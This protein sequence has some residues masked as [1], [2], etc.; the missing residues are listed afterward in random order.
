MTTTIYQSLKDRVVIIT[1]GGQGPMR[2]SLQRRALFRLSP[3]S[4]AK[5]GRAL[6]PRLNRRAVGH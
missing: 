1:G 4:M 2:T 5:T 3:S 6:W